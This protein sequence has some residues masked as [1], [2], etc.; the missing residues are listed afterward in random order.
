MHHREPIPPAAPRTA[1]LNTINIIMDNHK[2]ARKLYKEARKA[3]DTIRNNPQ[4]IPLREIRIHLLDVDGDGLG[5]WIE[6]DEETGELERGMLP[7]QHD[8]F[9]S[10]DEEEE[11]EN[12]LLN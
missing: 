8:M 1:K 7:L 10:F 5:L 12:V 9:S 6:Y 3:L 11:A 4:Q 2:I